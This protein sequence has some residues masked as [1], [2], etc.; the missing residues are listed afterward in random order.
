MNVSKITVVAGLF[1]ILSGN[2]NA[3]KIHGEDIGDPLIRKRGKKAK[4]VSYNTAT[5]ELEPTYLSNASD[6]F[7]TLDLNSIEPPPA[8]DDMQ[9]NDESC[10]TKCIVM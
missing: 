8:K 2:V 4:P 3:I 7:S 5:P 6:K 1:C 9:R 10:F